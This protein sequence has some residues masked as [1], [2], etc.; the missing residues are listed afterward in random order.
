VLATLR[1][2]AISSLAGFED[3]AAGT[4]WAAWDHRRALALIG[5]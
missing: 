2:L 3:I 1:N 4:R 5:V